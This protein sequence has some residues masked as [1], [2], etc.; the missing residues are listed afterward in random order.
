VVD[1][2][3]PIRELLQSYLEDQGFRVSTAQDGSEALRLLTQPRG[4][5][6]TVVLDL[7]LPG[8]SGF[9]VL[10][11]MQRSGAEAAVI[12]VSANSVTLPEALQ[13]G[14]HAAVAKP[15]DLTVLPPVVRRHCP[16]A[17]S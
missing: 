2:E 12:A 4:A 17:P 11:E 8:I 14:A 13:A 7:A 16:T 1:D 10:E 5:V 15:F 9:T 6:C 3:E